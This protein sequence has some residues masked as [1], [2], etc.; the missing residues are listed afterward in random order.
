M[1]NNMSSIASVKER[2]DDKDPGLSTLDTTVT[3][4][5][6]MFHFISLSQPLQQLPVVFMSIYFQVPDNA[7]QAKMRL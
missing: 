1:Y 6:L 3:L 2:W 4:H 5:D 7:E